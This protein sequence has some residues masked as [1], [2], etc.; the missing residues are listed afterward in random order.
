MSAASK[1]KLPTSRSMQMPVMDGH[2]TTRAIRSDPRYDCRRFAWPFDA[3]GGGDAFERV[4]QP[5]GR[6]H[7]IG[8]ERR[9]QRGRCVGLVFG[10]LPQHGAV[11]A[12]VAAHPVA[13]RQ[14][15][16]RLMR[17]PAAPAL[18]AHRRRP[19]PARQ[20]GGDRRRSD[21]TGRGDR[22]RD[23]RRSSAPRGSARQTPRGSALG[24][25]P[26]TSPYSPWVARWRM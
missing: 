7:V 20:A 5:F 15:L 10:I 12:L 8:G 17:A 6:L 23:Q 9:A 21:G 18:P 11:E 16:L 25:A 2:E 3:E 22:G 4:R 26:P 1:S 19:H 24:P 14:P 13:A